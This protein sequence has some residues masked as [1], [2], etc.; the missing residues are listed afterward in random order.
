MLDV[1]EVL[2]FWKK[3]LTKVIFIM[4][5]FETYRNY[6]IFDSITTDDDRKPIGKNGNILIY[7]TLDT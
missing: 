1:Y 4:G 7:N 3:E 6:R 2:F 5:H